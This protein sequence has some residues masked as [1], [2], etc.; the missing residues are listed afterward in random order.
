[1]NVMK[2]I[3]YSRKKI[4]FKNVEFVTRIAFLLIGYRKLMRIKMAE[5]ENPCHFYMFGNRRKSPGSTGGEQKT[6][7]KIKPPSFK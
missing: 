3:N 7:V 1:M 5:I 2:T 6:L 4:N